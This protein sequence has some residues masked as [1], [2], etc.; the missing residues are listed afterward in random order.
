MVMRLWSSDTLFWQLSI[1]HNMDVH[2]QV[3]HRLQAPTL[4]SI[5]SL[6]FHIGVPVVWM[7]RLPNFLRYGDQLMHTLCAHRVWLS[8]LINLKDEASFFY[9]G[10]IFCTK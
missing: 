4:P 2:H 10:H 1:D 3:K 5:E 8:L 6:I 7:A 9:A